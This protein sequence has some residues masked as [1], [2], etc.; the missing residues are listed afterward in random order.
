MRYTPLTGP[1]RN[2]RR[3]DY[4]KRIGKGKTA[5]WQVH[6]TF[7]DRKK[8][9]QSFSD[10]LYGGKEEALVWAKRFRSAMENEFAASDIVFGHTGKTRSEVEIGISRSG[11]KRKTSNGIRIHPYWQATWPDVSG[12]QI[13]RK[14]FDKKS[15]GELA[16][17]QKAIQARQDGVQRYQAIREG[18][19]NSS[20]GFAASLHGG[21][22]ERAPYTLFM[23]PVNL[24]IPVW[25]YMDF[26]KFVSLLENGGLYL[27]RII[28]LN[29]PFEGSFARGNEKLR[30]LVYRHVRNAF[31]LAAGDLMKRLRTWVAASCW[32]INEQESAGMWK[33]YTKTNE[34]VCIQSTF[35]KLRDALGSTVRV[36]VVR[37]VD[38]DKDWIPESNP[39]AP[40][41][42]KRKSFEHEHEVR[43]VIPLGDL[44][45]LQKKPEQ[46]SHP[47]TGIW[48]QVDLINL[49]EKVFVAPDA[50][51]WFFELVKKV[52][53]RYEQGSIPVVQSS[54]SATPFY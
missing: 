53:E 26:T 30:P 39:L 44:K 16:A 38:Y 7:K 4:V 11:S 29:D 1:L 19:A 6:F 25:R 46:A 3:V 51:V 40:F 31:G 27:P 47:P 23:P 37:Y 5:L 35:R 13:N 21:D 50:P 34:A 32:H 15:G 45:E 10:S 52:T 49:I 43:A 41:L 33:L 36:G 9:S 42:Y 54:L 24:D 12:K 2:I 28:D 17:K 22:A 20:D 18:K 8:V 14:F 48:Q